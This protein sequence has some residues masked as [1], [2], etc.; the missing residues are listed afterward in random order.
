MS[1]SVGLDR[2]EAQEARNNARRHAHLLSIQWN[3]LNEHF[4]RIADSELRMELMKIWYQN[5]LTHATNAAIAE[6]MSSM[7]GGLQEMFD[8]EE[9]DD[10]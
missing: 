5:M 3:A 4:P 10:E 8:T 6:G 1:D 7:F 2:D 9:E